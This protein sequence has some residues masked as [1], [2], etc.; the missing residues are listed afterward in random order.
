MGGE[1]RG[2][3]EIAK[4]AGGETL[5]SVSLK[6]SANGGGRNKTCVYSDT[7]VFDL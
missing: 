6:T 5:H 2:G 7:K 4:V 1:R 3:G